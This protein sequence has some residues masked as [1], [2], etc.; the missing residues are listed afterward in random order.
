LTVN[1]EPVAAAAAAAAA[2]GNAS[3]HCQMLK[4]LRA[5]TAS[6]K[7]RRASGRRS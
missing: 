5:V 2:A 3:Y 6:A 1:A 7:Q 4:H